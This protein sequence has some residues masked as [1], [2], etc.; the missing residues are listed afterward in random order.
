MLG[1]LDPLEVSNVVVAV[2]GQGSVSTDGGIRLC[3]RSTG[4]VQSSTVALVDLIQLLEAQLTR[5]RPYVPTGRRDRRRREDYRARGTG[6][7]RGAHPRHRAPRQRADGDPGRARG[8]AAAVGR[9]ART[10]GAAV[11]R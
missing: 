1:D 11:V 9:H 7:G 10:L 5:F 2:L 6:A 3:V 8:G 4:S